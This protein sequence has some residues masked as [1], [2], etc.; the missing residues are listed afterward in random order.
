MSNYYKSI[1]N[2]FFKP[3]TLQS[4]I[5]QQIIKDLWK[6]YRSFIPKSKNHIKKITFKTLPLFILS[7]T[8]LYVAYQL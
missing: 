1:Q 3:V 4:A 2:P 8:C 6:I 7:V 5:E